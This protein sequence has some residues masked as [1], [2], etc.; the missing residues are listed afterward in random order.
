MS[1]QLFYTTGCA[2]KNIADL[3][4]VVERC[5]AIVADIRFFVDAA[6]P[7]SVVELR[8]LFGLRYR[9]VAQLE[10]RAGKTGDAT[11]AHLALG[12]RIIL[13]WRTNVILLCECERLED[14]HRKLI[15]RELRRQNLAVEE[16]SSWQIESSPTTVDQTVQEIHTSTIG[17]EAGKQTEIKSAPIPN[18]AN[19]KTSAPQLESGTLTLRCGTPENVQTKTVEGLIAAGLIIHTDA[20][21]ST[22]QAITHLASGRRICTAETLNQAKGMLTQFLQLDVDW[23]KAVPWNTEREAHQL[24]EKIKNILLKAN[25]D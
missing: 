20:R 23:R 5:D 17:N 12:L 14:C 13:S 7:A 16:L 18:N 1:Q 6:S 4:A 25:K 22:L 2:N 8:K 10:A 19:A 24:K 9:R 11:V 21:D 3:L 15:A